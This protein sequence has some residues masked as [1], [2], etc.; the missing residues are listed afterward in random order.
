[1]QVPIWL[2]IVIS[3]TSGLLTFAISTWFYMLHEERKQKLEVFRN[4]MGNR[5]GLIQNPDPEVKREFFKALNEAFVVF[6]KSKKILTTI[7]NFNT[8]PNRAGD[9]FTLLARAICSDLKIPESAIKDEFFTNSF[10]P[11]Y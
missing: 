7:M 11:N 9:N 1:M 5:H 4:L 10:T 2:T 8:Y 3:L 6:G